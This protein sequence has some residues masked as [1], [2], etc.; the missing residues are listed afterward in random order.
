MCCFFPLL[1]SYRWGLNKNSTPCS[2][3]YCGYCEWDNSKFAFRSDRCCQML[4]FWLTHLC[5]VMQKISSLCLDQRM[6]PAVPWNHKKNALFLPSFLPRENYV[7]LVSFTLTIC[8]FPEPRHLTGGRF[9]DCIYIHWVL[10]DLRSCAV[11]RFWIT[12]ININVIT[13]QF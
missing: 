10:I 7:S 13:C 3:W 12:T 11:S 1:S 6:T 5:R 2:C 4:N 9:N 8:L